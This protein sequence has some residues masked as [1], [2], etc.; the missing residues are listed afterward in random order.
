MPRKLY[1]KRYASG[2]RDKYSVEQSVIRG[3]TS[4]EQTNGLYQAPFNLVAATPTQGMR[5]VKHVT[6][7]LSTGPPASGVN[8]A[9]YW[10]LVYVPEGY[11]VNPLN[12]NTGA[13][14]YEPNQ[15][16]M[17]CGCNDPDAGPVRIRSP[18]SRNLNSGDSIWLVVGTPVPNIS[19]HG[20]LQYAIT[21][22]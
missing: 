22:Q 13:N 5:K 9:I 1:R 18:L 15:F 11:S 16:V 4:T 6:I 10:A 3:I 17:A 2:A 7:S 14:F 12:G 19:V 8:T 20:I 21:L